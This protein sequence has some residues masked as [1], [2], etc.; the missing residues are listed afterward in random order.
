MKNK[1][2]TI[3]LWKGKPIE[4]LNKKELLEVIDYLAKAKLEQDNETEFL[5]DDYYEL[6]AKKKLGIK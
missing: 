1:K 6:L 4:N 2:S 3:G 5:G